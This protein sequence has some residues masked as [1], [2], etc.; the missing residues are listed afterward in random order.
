MPTPDAAHSVFYERI[1]S[2]ERAQTGTFLKHKLCSRPE[3]S[4]LVQ[5]HILQETQVESSLQAAQLRPKRARLAISLNEKIS[6]RPRP[7]ELVE[8][9][10]LPVEPEDEESGIGDEANSIK[11]P[12]VYTF[13]EDSKG[14]VWSL[15]QSLT[16]CLVALFENSILLL[17]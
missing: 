11:T 12:D 10:I 9:N 3:R 5:M 13:D 14:H 17:N 2:L 16:S 6:Q 4:E 15:S 1:R 7:M 8:K